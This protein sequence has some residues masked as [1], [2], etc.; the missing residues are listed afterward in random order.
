MSEKVTEE[1]RGGEEVLG[2]GRAHLRLKL[3]LKRKLFG[4]PLTEESGLTSKR[5]ETRNWIETPRTESAGGQQWFPLLATA[6]SPL[7]QGRWG[8]EA[9]VRG[10]RKLLVF[11][12]PLLSRSQSTWENCS[13]LFMSLTFL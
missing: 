4:T 3:W 8:P 11:V 1:S 6:Y 10:R 13:G 12:C 5:V 7:C 9:R 2:T